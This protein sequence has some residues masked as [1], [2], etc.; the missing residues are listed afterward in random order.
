MTK[1][2]LFNMYVSH[3]RDVLPELENHSFSLT[4]SIADLGANSV[5]RVEILMMTLETAGATNPQLI[6]FAGVR[7]IGEIIDTL[8]SKL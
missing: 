6:D 8:H 2:E 3:A 1:E 7:N 4:D 5:D